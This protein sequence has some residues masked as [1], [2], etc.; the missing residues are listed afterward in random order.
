MDFKK[1]S[2]SPAFSGVAVFVSQ[3]SKYLAKNGH[4]VLII[5]PA[6]D[7]SSELT[8]EKIGPNVSV[9]FLP[10]MPNPFRPGLRMASFS[11][12]YEIRDLLRK[13][14]PDIVH[15][16]DPAEVGVSTLRAAKKNRVPVVITN[17]SY[18][19]FILAYL[20]F[21]WP[22]DKLAEKM[23][24]NHLVKTYNDCR[25]VIT[26][27]KSLSLSLRRLGVEVPI[28]VVSNG[29]MI[30]RFRS[31]KAD[32]EILR[33]YRLPK[34]KKII[35]YVGRL[36]KDKSLETIIE[37]IPEVVAEEKS[38]HFVFVGEGSL[39][40][41]Y[42]ALAKKIKA[43]KHI[44][45]AGY[46][47]H[48]SRDLPQIY[49]LADIFV[50]PSLEGQSIATIEAMASGLPVV[51]ADAGGLKELVKNKQNGVRFKI[52]SS[53]ALGLALLFLLKNG[54]IAEQYGNEGRLMAESYDLPNVQ[55][56]LIGVYEK[57]IAGRKK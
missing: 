37:A 25:A 32:P 21:L 34:N 29:V 27:T 33:R 9:A 12:L 18:S 28:Y 55:K 38:A 51:A 53:R 30:R 14:K 31:G 23:V 45:W 19:G 54:K 15:L 41:E 2:K 52:G 39:K 3:F 17:H 7:E 16:Q 1:K 36:E 35:L 22:F 44:T 57:I 4:Q 42:K 56:Q 24:L 20:R 10:S 26:P 6:S 11:G 47:S 49:R 8:M 48:E 50:M 46:V 40:G 43:D 5:A 13:F